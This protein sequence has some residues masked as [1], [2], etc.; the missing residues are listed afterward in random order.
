MPYGSSNQ[1]FL[2]YIFELMI[3][4]KIIMYLIKNVRENVQ[5]KKD[6]FH[7]KKKF[8]LLQVTL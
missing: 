2:L 6:D 3:F 7:K 8:V 1:Y 4:L 5:E